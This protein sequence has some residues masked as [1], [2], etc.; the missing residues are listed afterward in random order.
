MSMPQDWWRDFFDGLMADFWH[1]VT[2]K[3]MTAAE[4]DIAVRLLEPAPGAELL[5]VPCGDGRHS[6]ALAARGFAVT[7]VDQSAKLLVFAQ[8]DSSG[9]QFERRDMR[10]LPWKHRFAGAC[11]LGNSFG[12][13][14][15]A[16][17]AA[18]L[19]AVHAALRPGGRLLL[20]A[21]TLET[22]LPA[23]QPRRWLEVG[24]LLW[25]SEVSYEPV[26][27]VLRSDYTIARGAERE[28]RTAWLRLR[29]LRAVIDLLRGAGFGE[30]AVFDGDG[31]PFRHG[32]QRA[33]VLATA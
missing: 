19:A 28:R 21:A 25:F 33:Y 29:S 10:E 16:G 22:V 8:E 2:T 7:G 23:L 17:D 6:H 9:A 4:V 18:F 15:D 32:S 31:A 20:D 26:S 24:D 1:Q 14:G 30:V 3:A 13:L 11:C 27:G 5:D 12:Y